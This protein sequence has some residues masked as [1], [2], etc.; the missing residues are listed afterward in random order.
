MI[1]GEILQIWV[2]FI[3]S[4]TEVYGFNDINQK[5]TKISRYSIRSRKRMEEECIISRYQSYQKCQFYYTEG[6][7]IKS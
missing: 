4:R 7:A 5:Y 2:W 1:S 6:V 3:R